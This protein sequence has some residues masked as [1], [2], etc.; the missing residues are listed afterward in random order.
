MNVLETFY[1]AHALAPSYSLMPMHIYI[2]MYNMMQLLSSSDTNTKHTEEKSDE[3]ESEKKARLDTLWDGFK[4]DIGG[5][6]KSAG[7]TERGGPLE[8]SSHTNTQVSTLKLVT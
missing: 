3:E 8:T 4:K 2:Y 6:S 7:M 1:Y 5:L